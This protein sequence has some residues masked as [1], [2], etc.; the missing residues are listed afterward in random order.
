MKRRVLA[1]RPLTDQ[2]LAFVQLFIV[3]RH[4]FTSFIQNVAECDEKQRTFIRLHYHTE[5]LAVAE[6]VNISNARAQ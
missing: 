3:G 2:L 5:R 6:L 4:N 1:T